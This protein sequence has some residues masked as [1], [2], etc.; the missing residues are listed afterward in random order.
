[1]KTEKVIFQGFPMLKMWDGF[2]TVSSKVAK[3]ISVTGKL[4]KHGYEVKT[5]LT[6]AGVDQ[7]WH[8]WLSRTQYHGITYF[9]I[10]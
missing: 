1:M 6:G 8:Y 2:L 9:Y 10:Y 4:P 7:D 5:I 3:Q